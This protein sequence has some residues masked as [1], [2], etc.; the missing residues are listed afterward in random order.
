MRAIAG[1]AWKPPEPV[2]PPAAPGS[3]RLAPKEGRDVE[4]I[5]LRGIVHRTLTHILTSMRVKSLMR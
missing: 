1:G 5:L 4:M 2:K 3:G